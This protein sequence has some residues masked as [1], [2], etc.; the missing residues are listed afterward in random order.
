MNR[1]ELIKL[2][3][4]KYPFFNGTATNLN[5]ATDEILG[6]L[7]SGKNLNEIKLSYSMIG[8]KIFVEVA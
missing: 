3:E 7:E 1:I 6:H 2:L 5:T 8:K 4:A